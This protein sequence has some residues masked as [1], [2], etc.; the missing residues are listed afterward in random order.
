MAWEH[1]HFPWYLFT[2]VQSQSGDQ[3]KPKSQV[4]LAEQP[5]AFKNFLQVPELQGEKYSKCE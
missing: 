2:K 3:V 1:I 4:S 5:Y